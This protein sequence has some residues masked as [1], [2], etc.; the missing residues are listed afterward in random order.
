MY[1]NDAVV[2]ELF[3]GATTY[4]NTLKCAQVLELDL[5]TLKEWFLFGVKVV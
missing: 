3:C 5:K 4:A 1:G 2:T